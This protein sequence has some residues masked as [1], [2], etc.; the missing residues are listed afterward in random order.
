ML[1]INHQKPPLQNYIY[2]GFLPLRMVQQQQIS[3]G[4]HPSSETFT[5]E[6]QLF[7]SGKI[8]IVQGATFCLDLSVQL[9]P[10]SKVLFID[11]GNVFN[12]YYI[13]RNF[14]EQ[15]DVKQALENISVSRPFT[16]YQLRQVVEFEIEKQLQS[17]FRVLIIPCIDDLFYED[18]L[19][20]WEAREVFLQTMKSLDALVKKQNIF[21][22]ISFVGKYFRKMYAESANLDVA[23]SAIA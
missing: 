23:A 9:Q 1:R 12:P 22:F 20:I 21:C 14:R 15:V 10:L 6:N 4:S 5:L 2:L 7:E 13:H 3:I 11:A 19:Q 18:G 17:G 16:I 8:T